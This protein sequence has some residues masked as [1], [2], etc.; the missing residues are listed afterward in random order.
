MPCK[1]D[2]AS[3]SWIDTDAALQEAA[4]AWRAHPAIGVDTEFQRTDT[5]FPLPG[6]YQVAAGERVYLL[7]PLAI[8]S[9]DPFVECLVD[10]A[11][12]KIMH[13]CSEDLE[14]IHHHLDVVPENV[15]DTQLANAFQS[16]D[17]SMSYANLVERLLQVSLGKHETRSNWLRR[18]L[19]DR[20]LRYAWEDVAF[21]AD[22]HSALTDRLADLGRREWFDEA[23]TQRG[24]FARGAPEEYYK[25][26]K[27]A[28]RL[29]GSELAR[30]QGL[31][32]WR[33]RR[34]MAEDVPRNRVVW[35]DHLV[36]FARTAELS[37]AAL[38]DIL[39]RPV[40]A[41]YG[42]ELLQVHRELAAGDG[43]LPPLDRPLTPAQG[44]VSRAL[45]EL[46]RECAQGIE[47]A[48][49]LVARKRDVDHCIRHFLDTRRL[50]PLY[51]GWR[52]P[53]VGTAFM[54]L[55]QER[56]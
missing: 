38:R 20:Q 13:A 24:E 10:P 48:H 22:L 31:C 49:E 27:K 51:C 9:W 41:R 43:V 54:T 47:L 40:A 21:L 44:Q 34:A 23:M 28:W 1:A 5:F 39:P 19:S 46:A 37:D 25:G 55:L 36:R 35:D 56:L 33:E 8:Q 16:I 26:V 17:Y 12:T 42:A 14:L 50:S 45:R 6:L 53:L 30:L 4:S 2:A 11:M 52:Q 3:V 32:A 15:F 7:D 18:P 29:N